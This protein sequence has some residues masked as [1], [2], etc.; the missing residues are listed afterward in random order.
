GPVVT[1]GYYKQPEA[2]REAF[3]GGW[4]HT[5]DVG[6]FDEEG[7]LYI[8]GRRSDLIISGGENVYPA[9][10]EAVLASHPAVAEAG[11]IGLPDPHWGEVPAALVVLRPGARRDPGE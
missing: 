6:R 8:S 1:A 3:Q 5:G 10:I 2:T 9:E 7:F 4:F 11:V